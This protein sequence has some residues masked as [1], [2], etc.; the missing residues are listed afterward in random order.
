MSLQVALDVAFKIR[1]PCW[2]PKAWNEISGFENIVFILF[3]VIS[4]EAGDMQQLRE[5]A[6]RILLRSFC[7][8]DDN[9]ISRSQH[10]LVDLVVGKTNQTSFYL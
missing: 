9:L 7:Q 3:L 1:L 2:G 10:G 5:W 4:V 6:S 8:K